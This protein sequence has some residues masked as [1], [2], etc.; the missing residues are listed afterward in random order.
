MLS[1]R[2][3]MPADGEPTACAILA[4]C[5]TCSKNL[6]AV[7]QISRALTQKGVAVLR[8][9]FTG[10]GQSEGE[11]AATNFSSNVEDLVA[12]GAFVEEMG[13]AP[14]ILIGHS[15]GGAAAIR[16]G[17]HVRGA[18]AVVTIGAPFDPLHVS[19]LI[20]SSEEE[21]EATG[22]TEVRIGGRAFRV[23]K[24]LLDDLRRGTLEEDLRH[25][26]R[27][28]LVL[29][30]PQD[31]TVGIENA[32]QIYQAAR[33][34]KS[35]VSLD[36]ADH[37]LS[38]ERDA[39]YVAEVIAAWA[40]RY[41][42]ERVPPQ[43]PAELLAEKWPLQ[44]VQVKLTHDKIHAVDESRTDESN[45]RVDRVRRELELSGPLSADQLERL[46]EIADRC[47][48]HRTLTAGLHVESTLAGVASNLE[49]A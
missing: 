24:Q 47:P 6:N 20:A 38:E 1:A 17:R 18:R 46:L 21:I 4:Q 11:F 44:E 15:L 30:S 29:H 23:R 32:A 13:F 48:V 26:D 40:S 49:P 28:L 3:D 8:F 10:L 22:E 7:V 34:P 36:Q 19:K 31:Q 43:T 41:L 9:D 35:Y 42:Q 45:A 12:A 14:E 37:L 39:R 27:P 33:H 25:L 5:F 16:A 2:L